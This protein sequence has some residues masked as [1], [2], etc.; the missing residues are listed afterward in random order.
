[1]FWVF[2]QSFLVSSS[3]SFMF[4]LIE[5]FLVSGRA[6]AYHFLEGHIIK[7]LKKKKK[8]H[9][10]LTPFY[11]TGIIENVPW[12]SLSLCSLGFL[13]LCT[14]N[15]PWKK[16]PF[17]NTARSVPGNMDFWDFNWLAFFFHWIF[18]ISKIHG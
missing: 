1:M 17:Y 2:R 6:L 8:T 5:F 13:F 9:K 15:V 4:L 16:I 3:V 7:L 10:N 12:I 18:W 14:Y 11:F